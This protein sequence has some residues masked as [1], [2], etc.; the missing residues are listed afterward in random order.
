MKRRTF[1]KNLTA[2]SGGLAVACAALGRREEIFASRGSEARAAGFG[3]LRPVPSKNTGE[4]IL[5]LP[6]GFSYNVFGK[7]GEVMSDGRETPTRHDGMATFEDGGELRL[8]RN[9]EITNRLV[10]I[11]GSAIGSRP[12]DETA[13]GGTTTLVI[14]LEKRMPKRDFVSL[15]GTLVNCAGGPS[16]WGSWI[17]CEETTIGQTVITNERGDKFGGFSKPHGYCFEVSAASDTEVDPVPLKSMGRFS[18]EA[19]AFDQR[20]GVVYLTED[21]RPAGFYRFLPNKKTR[22]REGGRLEMLALRNSPNRDLRTGQQ[23]GID[24]YAYWVPID[25]PDPESADEDSQAVQKQGLKKGAAIFTRLEGCFTDQKGVVYFV[26]TEGGEQKDGQVWRYVPTG[27]DEGRLQLVYESPGHEVLEMPDNLCPQPGSD[28]IFICE[29]GDYPGLGR[30]ID[31]YMKILSADGKIADF[32]KNVM[33]GFENS[34]FAGSSFDRKGKVLF[35]NLQAPGVTLA[36]WGD[37]SGFRT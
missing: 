11:E 14:D 15:S 10:P 29:D 36:I 35:V 2:A 6:E 21:N 27:K 37:W 12:Y 28:L 8:V 17:S 22:L 30:P 3:S 1:L 34:E 9:H 25:D 20:S 31:N 19:V 24:Y 7:Q 26:S 33:P 13:G 32:A 18:H 4:T 16:P 5:S 23:V